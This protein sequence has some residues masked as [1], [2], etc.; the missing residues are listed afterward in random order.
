MTQDLDPA[1]GAERPR[2]DSRFR[3]TAGRSTSRRPGAGSSLREAAA[4]GTRRRAAPGERGGGPPRAAQGRESRSIPRSPAGRSW[5]R[6]SPAKVQPDVRPPD[7]PDRPPARHLASRQGASGAIRAVVER[8]EVIVA[9]TELANAFSEQNDP[10]RAAPRVRGAS[11]S[12]GS[13]AT[14]RPSSWTPTTFARWSS[15]FRRPAASASGSTG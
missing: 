13:A 2:V 11:W 4:Q 5:T 6:S 14:T 1:R 3:S 7:L 12:S 10:R 8:F 9:G 15:A